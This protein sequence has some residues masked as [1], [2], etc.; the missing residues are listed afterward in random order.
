MFLFAMSINS[1]WKGLVETLWTVGYQ[2]DGVAE[3][4][5]EENHVQIIMSYVYL[6]GLPAKVGIWANS[7]LRA[8]ERTRWK[9]QRV[10]LPSDKHHLSV[11]RSGARFWQLPLLAGT[12]TFWE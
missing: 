5:C 3:R 1:R 2:Q 6:L 4:G 12:S 7:Y 8:L 11:G 10:G 9:L